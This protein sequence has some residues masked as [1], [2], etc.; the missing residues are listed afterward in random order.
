MSNM[1][2]ATSQNGV[3]G[4]GNSM[5]W[6][7]PED[8]KWFKEMTLG[9]VLI[10]GRKTFESLPKGLPGR[11]IIVLSQS[12]KPYPNCVPTLHDAFY[13]ASTRW[14]SRPT[15]IAGGAQIYRAALDQRLVSWIFLTEIPEV[16]PICDDTVALSFNLL[17]GFDLHRTLVNDK[18]PRLVHKVYRCL[19]Q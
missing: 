8:L 9:G 14:P 17:A 2:I 4:Q 7:Y 15:W 6:H 10:M 1:I 5:P 19:Q 16:S 11:E 18:D 13:L 12:G 3:I